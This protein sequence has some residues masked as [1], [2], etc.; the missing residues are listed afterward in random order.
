M[1]VYKGIMQGSIFHGFEASF[2]RSALP[3]TEQVVAN[4]KEDLDNI[5]EENNLTRLQETLDNMTLHIHD[6]MDPAT[7]TFT[8]VECHCQD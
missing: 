6:P 8:I 3:T 2:S 5:L 7:N 4:F 1:P